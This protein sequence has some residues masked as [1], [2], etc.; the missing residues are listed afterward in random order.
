M[1]K[2]IVICLAVVLASGCST[3]YKAPKYN[4]SADNIMTLKTIEHGDIH[5]HDFTN[6]GDFKNKCRGF[7]PIGL[8]GKV[9]FA[10]YISSALSDELKFAGL[11]DADKN[12]RVQLTGKITKIDFS[13]DKGE[14]GGE[15]DIGL[16]LISSNGQT[17]K[18]R[19]QHLYE[20]PFSGDKACRKTA[21]EFLVAVQKMVNRVIISPEF[22]SLIK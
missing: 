2:L 14:L 5:V 13:T 7:H 8:P 18:V 20:A 3:V 12:P 11:Y 6:Y 16:M 19:G 15:W 10:E 22:K 21:E 1:H 9:T 4:M 17:M